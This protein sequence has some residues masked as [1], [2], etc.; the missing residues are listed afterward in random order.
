MTQ[1]PEYFHYCKSSECIIETKITVNNVK[2]LLN[3]NKYTHSFPVALNKIRNIDAS[4]DLIP[5]IGRDDNM[6]CT[7]CNEN[8]I[9]ENKCRL[10]VQIVEH[11]SKKFNTR[12]I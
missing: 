1:L 7:I 10:H 9:G 12:K 6:L 5:I 2:L 4:C 8:L 3:S 11:K